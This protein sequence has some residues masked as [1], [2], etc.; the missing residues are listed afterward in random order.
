MSRCR[1]IL[2]IQILSVVPHNPDI[3]AVAVAAASDLSSF[4]FYQ[5]GR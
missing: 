1:K 2:S 4:T 3:P 5:R